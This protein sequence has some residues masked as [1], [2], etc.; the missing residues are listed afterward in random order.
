M[1]YTHIT[2]A[3]V[4]EKDNCFLLVTDKTNAGLKLNQ[5]AGHVETNEDIINAVIREVHEETSMQ[6]TP[7]KLI[8]IYLYNPNPENIYL[9][10]C[11][12]GKTSNVMDIPHPQPNDD[13][14]IAANW[15]S[16]EE[17]RKNSAMLRSTLV[18]RCID[19]YLKGIEFPLEVLANHRDNIKVYLD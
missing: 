5:P 17:I 4:I 15:Y 19:D 18:M 1:T 13:G 9:R 16:L 10:F 14:V 3:A 6:F 7:E 11:F 12:K 8:G 2:V